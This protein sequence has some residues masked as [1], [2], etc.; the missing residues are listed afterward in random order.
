VDLE[1]RKQF[2]IDRV[3]KFVDA[4]FNEH[5]KVY[6]KTPYVD[7]RSKFN[8]MK[9]DIERANNWFLAFCTI[10]DNITN[11]K[12]PFKHRIQGVVRK[13]RNYRFTCDSY[14][15]HL[16]EKTFDFSK[17]RLSVYLKE[18][19]KDNYFEKGLPLPLTSV[20]KIVSVFKGG[21]PFKV[22]SRA[23]VPDSNV[24]KVFANDLDYDFTKLQNK[25]IIPGNWMYSNANLVDMATPKKVFYNSSQL[26]D[27]LFSRVGVDFK[28]PFIRYWNIEMMNGVL[29]KGKAFPGLLTSKLFG[30]KR[31]LTTGFMKTYAKFYFEKVIKRYKQVLDLSLVTVGG[32]EKRVTYSEG[33][34]VLKTRVVLMMEDIPTLIGQSVAVP[35]TKA[36]QRLNEGY[37]FVGRSLE[38]RNYVN[39]TNELMRDPHTTIVFNAD[40][41]GH[42]N[43]VD[44]H[45]LAVAFGVL[46]LCFP[47]RWKFMDKLFVY[48]LST[49]CF[50]HVVIP[51]SQFIYRLSK[52][53]ATGNPFTSL[54]NTTVAYMTFATAINNVATREE[55]LDTRLFVA[56]DDVIGVI[57]LSIL[58]KLSDEITQMS[59][60]KIDPITDHCGPL[61]S[62]DRALQRSF[63][64][65]KFTPMGVAWND[66]ELL[67][68]LYTSAGG[69]ARTGAEIS[70]ITDM[71]MNGPC[72]PILNSKV[73]KLIYAH[74]NNPRCR[75]PSYYS[76]PCGLHSMPSWRYSSNYLKRSTK[77]YVY[78]KGVRQLIVKT[79]DNRMRLAFRWFNAG[80][81]FPALGS[82]DDSYWIDATKDLYPPLAYPLRMTLRVKLYKYYSIR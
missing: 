38:Q 53:I 34:K 1:D 39:I 61:Y 70:R 44:E 58:E 28:L 8:H 57:P 24:R 30:H 69:L 76:P 68:N 59:G 60:M 31:A 62:N 80:Q 65:K 41:S 12:V 75:G 56:G 78:T 66:Y 14:T 67:D 22:D 35:L 27:G 16:E 17:I 47:A 49:M 29:T 79:F 25:E 72:D 50:K 48:C 42:D 23:Y 40:F 13:F 32:R 43:N 21:L 19:N 36:F 9:I 6:L 26:I 46:R 7:P 3:N 73:R 77:K 81:P 55:I 71:V 54:V 51:G 2:H 10:G 45:Q 4:W 11:A 33:F 74:F 64:K 15:P 63:L 5:R 18:V 82:K 52:G 20:S 37:N